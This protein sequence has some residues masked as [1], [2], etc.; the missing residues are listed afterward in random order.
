MISSRGAVGV[1]CVGILLLGCATP[2][3]TGVMAGRWTP[4][5]KPPQPI[6][7]SWESEDAITGPMFITLGKGGERFTWN[8][9]RVTSGTKLKSLQPI[10]GPWSAI[11]ASGGW[12]QEVDP[13][14]W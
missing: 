6:V 9:L 3:Q 12:A 2:P 1:V 5:G 7:I 11:R 13:W 8:Y 14:W 4:P 10:L